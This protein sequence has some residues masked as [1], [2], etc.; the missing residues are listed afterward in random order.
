MDF[1]GILAIIVAL[2]ATFATWMLFDFREFVVIAGV[3]TACGTVIAF[4]LHRRFRRESDEEQLS[5]IIHRGEDKEP[6]SSD[7]STLR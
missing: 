5:S 1:W 4:Y 3:I 6:V 7:S 2:F